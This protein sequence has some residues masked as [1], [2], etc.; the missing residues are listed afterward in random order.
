MGVNFLKNKKVLFFGLKDCKNSKIAL[1]IL[2]KFGCK[3]TSILGKKRIQDFPRKAL[4]W[5]GDFILS[6]RN[7]WLIPK[8]VLKKAKYLSI[9]FHPSIPQ[10]PGT[11]SCSWAIY[12]SVEEFGLTVHLMNEKY[13]NGKILKVYKFK[14][15]F[16]TDL[17]DLLK[18]SYNFSI[19]CFKKYLTLLDKKS[20]DQINIIKNKESPYKWGKDYKKL[21][22]LNIMRYISLEMSKEEI[23]KRIKAFYIENYPLRLS[24]NNNEYKLIKS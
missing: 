5:S 24:L 18:L 12:D 1:E 11:G 2:D 14:I 15:P 22:D 3:T 16:N 10:Y 8:N 6:Y 9:N 4:N 7:Y 17:E 21:K 20:S 13:D 19:L 23:E